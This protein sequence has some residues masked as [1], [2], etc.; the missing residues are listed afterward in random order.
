MEFKEAFGLAES[1]AEVEHHHV[2]AHD[3]AKGF[4]RNKRIAV[5]VSRGEGRIYEIAQLRD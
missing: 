2:A 1:I 5:K 4:H 3:I